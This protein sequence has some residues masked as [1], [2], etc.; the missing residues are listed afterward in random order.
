MTKLWRLPIAYL[1]T[2]FQKAAPA[3]WMPRLWKDLECSE[4]ELSPRF[5]EATTA[6]RQEFAAI[7][8][9]VVGFKKLKEFL[10]PVGR[11]N[12]GINYWDVSRRCYGQLIYHKVFA[13]A[14][15]NA[16]RE[17][18]TIAFTSAVN[19]RTFSCTNVSPRFD[20]LPSG[21]VIRIRSNKMRS[22]LMVLTAN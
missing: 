18:L 20:S 16:E 1:I 15:F 7:G 6:A 12:G 21:K 19:D 17:S 9:T 5:W 2:R 8:F 10:N 22:M 11:D 13:P 3:G 14:P 4:Q